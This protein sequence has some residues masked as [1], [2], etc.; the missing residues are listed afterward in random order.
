MEAAY[1]YEAFI[2]YRH[3][4]PDESMAKKLHT[5]IE[6]FRIPGYIKKK[7]GKAKMGRVFRDAEELPLSSD[8]GSDIT[9]ALEQSKWLIVV[10]SPQLP[11]S[12]WCLKEIDIFIAL[13]RQ[14][15]ILT[16]LVDGEPAESFPPQLCTSKQGETSEREPLAADVRGA[17]KA[18]RLKKL[19]RQKLKL[20]A[21]ILGVEYDALRQRARERRLRAAAALGFG[22]A[23]LVGGFL[24]YAAVQ[25]HK[26]EAQRNNAL[27][28]QSLYLADLSARV[29]GEGDR[30]VALLLA[31]E[32]LPR[33]LDQPE[34]P[35]VEEAAVALKNAL[36]N[37][38]ELLYS[39]VTK[40][41]LSEKITSFRGDNDTVGV[42]CRYEKEGGQLRYFSVKT[43]EEIT[44]SLL[45]SGSDFKTTLLS[46][47]FKHTLAPV[48]FG[49]NDIYTLDFSGNRKSS[50][51]SWSY[52]EYPDFRIASHYRLVEDEYGFTCYNS[53][54]AQLYMSYMGASGIVN[55][56][57]DAKKIY[58]M[59]VLPVF[60]E[61]VLVAL[62]GV[63]DGGSTLRS[64]TLSTGALSRE[65][66]A[67]TL[68]S[69]GQETEEFYYRGVDASADG[70]AALGCGLTSLHV[71]STDDC[72]LKVSISALDYAEQFVQA[73]F[74]P[75]SG[76]LAFLVNDGNLYLYNYLKKETVLKLD[77]GLV[78]V[79]SFQWSNDGDKILALCAD[80]CARL[81]NANNGA[82]MQLFDTGETLNSAVFACYRENYGNGANDD[83]ILL[84]GDYTLTV[85]RAGLGEDYA[86]PLANRLTGAN[87]GGCTA[88]AFSADSKSAAL[89]AAN[90][91]LLYDA[92]SGAL[93][94]QADTDY[95]NLLPIGSKSFLL[96]DSNGGMAVYSA[97]DG[98]LEAAF[99]PS[100]THVRQED[101]RMIAQTGL[102]VGNVQTNASGSLLL[103]NT[104][105]GNDACV[106]LY[107]TRTYKEL[108]QVGLYNNADLSV[109]PEAVQAYYAKADP[110]KLSGMIF[111]SAWFLSE[112]EVLLKYSYGKYG[113]APYSRCELRSLKDGALLREYE[114]PRAVKVYIDLG[115][116]VYTESKGGGEKDTYE[117][118]DIYTG[119]KLSP[120]ELSA[121]V[122][123][124]ARY[125]EEGDLD[126][127]D[128]TLKE[129]YFD[130]RTLL[131]ENGLLLEKDSGEAYLR[132][133]SDTDYIT[134]YAVS[135]DGQ[136]LIYRSRDQG[137]MPFLLHAPALETLVDAAKELL[138][139]RALTDAERQRYFANTID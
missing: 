5:A 47:S 71:F 40:I 82:L 42:F 125:T 80:G 107:D 41:T 28:N 91:L 112:D 124:S 14:D 73:A 4:E 23:L 65:F 55:T 87:A 109:A 69:K 111:L 75:K 17:T 101:G 9:R 22:A 32:A 90:K 114:I 100:F 19:R 68:D 95:S 51:V 66:Y 1:K 62:E 38:D 104:G 21:P 129:V 138:Q 136:K 74:S 13:G 34:K 131:K 57:D 77:V 97:S 113:M 33:N 37:T 29:Y 94:G 54:T 110:A 108:W 31:L 139:G 16:L 130:G 119:Q 36:L 56:V 2:S 10:C 30:V 7:T 137:G 127:A 50:E 118:Y 52:Y 96:Y 128:Y 70:E 105:S 58:D 84:A 44:D 6:T 81:Y 120:D 59:C 53:E 93:K 49:F 12:K 92:E 35:Y 61:E 11:L 20:L 24:A 63:K 121:A 64:Y 18:I 116:L 83:T 43:G 39:P 134:L 60:N 86:S 76:T 135:P 8:L 106:F 67:H 85:Y 123:D 117:Y 126:L 122:G 115:V 103:I 88:A 79:V 102:T 48:L 78:N 89:L 132:L 133:G 98:A 26:I 3:L 45:P 72:A 99:T 25:S 15:R 46:C 27:R